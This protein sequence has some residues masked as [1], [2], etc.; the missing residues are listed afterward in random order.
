ME[1]KYH[2]SFVVK[3]YTI[4]SMM[5]NIWCYFTF[6]FCCPFFKRLDRGLVKTFKLCVP[7]EIRKIR[8][9][10][11]TNT[12]YSLEW[13]RDSS[14]RV[15]RYA[16]CKLK[17]HDSNKE[18]TRKSLVVPKAQGCKITHPPQGLRKVYNFG[19]SSALTPLKALHLAFTNENEF[20]TSTFWAY[21][22]FFSSSYE[23]SCAKLVNDTSFCL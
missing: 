2:H 21:E 18:L 20:S 1:F 12:N 23:T 6:V 8:R 10:P 19:E 7:S 11:V 13:D 4:L 3:L 17:G 5:M 16:L 9:F 15:H 14:Y 22:T